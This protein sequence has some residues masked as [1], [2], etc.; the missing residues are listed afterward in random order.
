[1]V[2]NQARPNMDKPHRQS[3]TTTKW[4]GPSYENLHRRGESHVLSYHPLPSHIIGLPLG[5]GEACLLPQGL[6]LRKE[7]P[8][9]LLLLLDILRQPLSL[10]SELVQAS[11]FG[12]AVVLMPVSSPGSILCAAGKVK[13]ACWLD[14]G[15]LLKVG[16]DGQES[17][18]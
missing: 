1:M 9:F 18:G 14:M 8:L 4:E 10:L 12:R 17:S 11:P 6:S 5:P 13:L 16:G 2:P 7:I 15:E 3:N